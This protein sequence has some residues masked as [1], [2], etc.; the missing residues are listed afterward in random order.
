MNC[1]F[2]GYD[3]RTSDRY[4]CPNCNGEAD[5][6]SQA[7]INEEVRENMLQSDRLATESDRVWIL[8]IRA[9]GYS[10]RETVAAYIEEYSE[11]THMLPDCIY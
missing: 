3:M 6:T 9:Q 4:G 10:I 5:M 7:K 1:P 2:C 11:E 8:N